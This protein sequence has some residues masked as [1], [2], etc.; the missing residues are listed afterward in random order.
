MKSFLTIVAFLIVSTHCIGQKY[1]EKKQV[2]PKAPNTAA[3][4]KFVDFPVTLYTGAPDVSIPIYSIGLKGISVPIGISF[5]SGGVKVDA[6]ASNVGYNWALNAGG[7][8]SIEAN[9]IL[10]EFSGFGYQH[11]QYQKVKDL[12]F[13]TYFSGGVK[14]CTDILVVEDLLQLYSG[15]DFEYLKGLHFGIDD[16]EPDMY[17]FNFPGGAG[18]FFQDENGVFRTIPFSKIKIERKYNGSTVRGYEITDEKGN[19]FEYYQLEEATT[20]SSNLCVS[21]GTSPSSPY[22]GLSRSYHLTSIRTLFG[23]EIE[24]FYSI[25]AIQHIQYSFSRARYITPTAACNSGAPYS[26]NCTTGSTTNAESVSIDSI[27]SSDGTGIFF[28]YEETERQDLPGTKALKEIL[29]KSIFDNSV[30]KKYSLSQDYWSGRL[31]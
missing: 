14:S 4:D 27:K 1:F 5:H 23:E 29:V 26:Y 22:Q 30:L 16:S 25:D 2:L 8:I 18:K 12:S 28:N 6:I 13:Q 24:F 9:G 11:P 7:S 17:S 31:L 21:G 15:T 3:I 20:N 19:I 10:D